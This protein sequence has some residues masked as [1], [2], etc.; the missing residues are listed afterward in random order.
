MRMRTLFVMI[1]SALGLCL[2]M[3]NPWIQVP[4]LALVYPAGLAWIG[5][6]AQNRAEAFR[7]GWITGLL[8]AMGVVYWVA[9]PVREFGGLPW[10]LAIGCAM[11]MAAYLGLYGGIF[12]AAARHWDTGNVWVRAIL[13]GT[14]WYLLEWVRG[15]LLTGF[16]W[17]LLA[18]AFVPWPAAIQSAAFVGAYGLGGVLASKVV[19]I[20]L[21]LR[22]RRLEPVL[23]ALGLLACMFAGGF[24]RL[25]QPVPYGAALDVLLVQGNVDQNVKWD[26]ER[27][28]ATTERYISLSES[29]LQRFGKKD[30]APLL[31]IW[32]ETAMPFDFEN[33]RL[34]DLAKNFT[35]SEGVLL[36]T[37][38]VGWN[39][40]AG[41]Y[42][43]RAYLLEPSMPS[44]FGDSAM[45]WYEKE[46]L[47]P[48]GE[49]VPPGLDFDFLQ[50]FMQGVGDFVPGTRTAPL[51][52][53]SRQGTADTENNKPLVSGVLICYEAIFPEL[54][55]KHVAQGADLLIDI[56]NDAW[57]GRT[58]APEQ[59]LQLSVLRAVEQGKVLVRGTNTGF[60]AFVDARGR[61]LAQSDLF[62]A[63]TIGMRVYS[64]AETTVFYTLAPI[65]PVLGLVLWLGMAYVLQRARSRKRKPSGSRR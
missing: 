11:A 52:L 55:R 23:M 14:V 10:P 34:T 15:W 49:Y 65:L 59:H 6:E 29:G 37:G 57:F 62:R 64:T 56:S 58:S 8:G 43:N 21:G 35:N 12:A 38:S 31:V 40:R 9:V 13:L 47:L 22:E 27:Q 45:S 30:D 18:A 1:I 54:A 26:P 28:F 41:K 4:V 7:L 42:L 17:M 50:G 48:F 19:L 5:L 61:I 44:A 53:M 24:W 36:L 33:A 25:S 20:V 16:P 46:H 32:P 2:G 60:S 3:P 39:P 51:P 63:E